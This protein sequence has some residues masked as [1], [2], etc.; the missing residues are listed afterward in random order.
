MLYILW[1][2]IPNSVL[3][4]YGI[5]YYPSKYWAVALPTW[6]C[7]TVVAVYWAYEGCAAAWQ[8]SAIPSTL[9]AGYSCPRYGSRSCRDEPGPHEQLS[10]LVQ[11]VASLLLSAPL[12]SQPV[13]DVGTRAWRPVQPAGLGHAAQRGRWNA[14]LLQSSSARCPAAC[15]RPTPDCQRCA[16]WR[17]DAT[18]WG[19]GVG[20]H[21]SMLSL[22]E[23]LAAGVCL[24]ILPQCVALQLLFVHDWS[25]LPT[26][27]CAACRGRAAL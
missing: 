11:P 18:R 10:L 13:H 1:A 4:S 16:V 23:A 2:Y 6:V 17:A 8:C 27:F 26:V 7:V 3:E 25:S 21:G 9:T 22:K 14:Q 15:G 19:M 5:H 20:H 12:P 24:L